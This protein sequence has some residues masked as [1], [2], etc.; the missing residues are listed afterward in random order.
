MNIN[1]DFPFY[2]MLILS[3]IKI[4]FEKNLKDF[5]KMKDSDII[6][7]KINL[8]NLIIQNNK[9]NNKFNY[10]LGKYGQIIEGNGLEY[11][12]QLDEKSFIWKFRDFFVELTKLFISYLISPPLQIKDIIG[13]VTKLP[14]KDIFKKIHNKFLK[15]IQIRN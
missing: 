3:N 13:L 12:F 15:K 14:F 1:A 10:I 5:N 4:S 9:N 11:I 6:L 2:H 7:D 8:S